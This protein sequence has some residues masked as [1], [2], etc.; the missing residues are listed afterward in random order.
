MRGESAS[1]S[2][3]ASSSSRCSAS[4]S[5]S[6]SSVSARDVFAVWRLP[7]G[8]AVVLAVSVGFG[9][10]GRARP[11]AEEP[12]HGLDWGGRSVRGSTPGG[13]RE[14]TA[15]MAATEWEI[16]TKFKALEAVMD[17]RLKRL[18]A[19]AE[20]DA[21][22]DGGIAAVERATKM[23]RTTIRG[24]RDE[25]RAGARVEDVV[26]VRRPG[27]GEAAARRDEPAFGRSAGVAGRPRDAWR[28]EV[29]SSLDVQE[30]TKAR[31]RA[32][33]ARDSRQSAE[34]SGGSCIPASG[35]SLQATHKTPTE[36]TSHPDRNAQFEFINER[37]EEHHAR[38]APVISVDPRKRRNSSAISRTPGREWQP[39]G[40][41]IPVRV[42]DFIDKDLGKAI[43]YGVYDLASNAAWVSVGI[44]HDTP[45][46]A[47]ESIARWWRSMGK[48]AYPDATELLITADGGGS[49]GYRAKTTGSWNSSDSRPASPSASRTSRPAR[50]SG[51]RSSTDSSATSPKTGE[52]DR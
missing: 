51:T 45:E 2:G 16:R 6:W 46:F 44:D 48:K 40:E 49:N 29:A 13:R 28:S 19:G 1:R 18:W 5:R 26:N 50:P 43:P 30:H 11:R 21:Y 7:Q 31:Q 34:G 37:V 27:G 38:G 3:C 33:R 23:S 47:V 36:G 42:H 41:P 25:L 9:P 52:D 15:S 22:G 14:S 4:A 39:A 8:S 17:E 20:A 32:S 24:G 35:Y 12:V 10:G